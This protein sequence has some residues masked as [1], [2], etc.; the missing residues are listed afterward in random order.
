MRRTV[1]QGKYRVINQFEGKLPWSVYYQCKSGYNL[2]AAFNTKD[3]ARM[4]VRDMNRLLDEGG[5]G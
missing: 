5:I 3:T 4:Y 2:V 1:K